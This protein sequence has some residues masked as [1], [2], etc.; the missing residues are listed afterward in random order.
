[1]EFSH[2]PVLFNET[3]ESLR[4]APDGVYVDC[5]AGGGGHAAAILARLSQN[6]RLIAIDR[7]PDAVAVLR[8]RFKDA[9]NVTVVH[10]NYLNIREIAR[11]LGVE[12]KVSGVLADLGV[13][14]YQLDTPERGFSFHAD[15]PLDM[16]MSKEGLS[17]RDVVNTYPESELKRILYTYG[18]E[19]FAPSVARRIVAEREKQPIETTLQLAEIVK[20][21]IP[22]KARREG[23]HPARR[24]FQAVRIEVNGELRDLQSAVEGMFSVLKVGGVL[25]VITFHSLEDRTVKNVFRALSAG[26]TCPPDFPVCVC[27]K[28]PQGKPLGKASPSA[29]ELEENPRAR[30]ARLRSIEKL[31]L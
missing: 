10:D 1:M 3:V 20:S 21:G 26:C 6:G 14:S 31:K 8:E 28:T 19:K 23:G 17:A 30:S 25:S 9:P 15:A 13:S 24:A 5:T 12:G 4:I 11:V 7:D 27:G 29:R 2:I 22:A 16:R 18:E